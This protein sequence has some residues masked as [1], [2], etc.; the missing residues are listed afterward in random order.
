MKN[1]EYYIR[2][3]IPK[4]ELLKPVLTNSNWWQY[5]ISTCLLIL[6]GPIIPVRYRKVYPSSLQEYVHDL[7]ITAGIVL[8]YVCFEIWFGQMLPYL[9]R[10]KGYYFKGKFE[11]ID[12]K[13]FLGLTFLKLKP[14]IANKIRI[15]W[16]QFNTLRIGDVILIE[17][18]AFGGIKRIS[19]IS[20][21]QNRVKRITAH[22]QSR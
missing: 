18:T 1:E 7:L 20:D 16:R 8:C 11:V 13:V 21:F 10:R 9:E 12:K 19:K 2:I 15:G 14:G 4:S 6:L 17:R 3:K 22:F 5:L